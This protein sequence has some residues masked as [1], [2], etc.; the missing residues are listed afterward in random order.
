FPTDQIRT[1]LRAQLQR[2]TDAGVTIDYVDSHKHLHKFPVFAK[3]L[4]EVLADFGIERVRR[5][6][7]QFEGPT[8]TRAT[9]WLDRVWKERI[10]TAFTSTDHFFMADG[11]ETNDWWNRV[12]LDLGG[13]LEVG[14]HPGAKEAWR[15]NEQRGLDALAVRLR[16][17]GIV[18]SSWRDVAV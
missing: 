9:V 6:Q 15:A 4:P 5:V 8:L 14:T 13:S 10:T 18:P 1:E 7:N 11:T 16:D 2:V 12:P 3:L 17:R